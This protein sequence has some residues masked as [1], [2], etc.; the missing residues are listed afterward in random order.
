MECDKKPLILDADALNLAAAYDLPL[1]SYQ[2]GM[3]ITPHPGEMAR[4]CKTSILEIIGNLPYFAADFARKNHLICVLKDAGTVVSDGRE[5]YINVSGNSGMAT[6]GSGDVLTGI[7]AGLAA[8]GMTLFEA[9]KLGVYLHGCAGDAAAQK[10][11]KRSLLAG[12]IAE[13]I[14]DILKDI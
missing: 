11:G 1:S 9:A 5:R 10:R 12:D 14:A 8:S 13:S 3:V 6:G 4:L 7:V 2:S